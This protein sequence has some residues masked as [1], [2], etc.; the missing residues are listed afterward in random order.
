MPLHS[1]Y[2]VKP[3][4]MSWNNTFWVM[5]LATFAFVFF[6]LVP[7]HPPGV[8]FKEY[9]PLHTAME[10]FA[11]VIAGVTFAI[12]WHGRNTLGTTR[13]ALCAIGFLGVAMLDA[14]HT[15]SYPGMPDW[16]TPSSDEKAINFWFFARYL[17]AFSILSLVLGSERLTLRHGM[18]WWILAGV[19][20]IVAISYWLVFWH[21]SWLPVFIVPQKG[22]TSSKILMEWLL[23]A[24]ALMT[25]V[26]IWRKRQ[27]VTLY[28]PRFLVAALWLGGLSE[29]CFSLYVNVADVFNL[30]GHVYKALSY[31][32]LYQ[33]IVTGSV[34]LPYTLLAQ[35]QA[36]TQQLIQHIQEVFWMASADK[37]QFFFVSPAY[38]T[39]WQRSRDSLMES[40]NSWYEAIHPEDREHV[41]QTISSQ[42]IGDY[43]LDYRIVRPDGS[44]RWI[45]DKAFPICDAKGNVLRIAGVADDITEQVKAAETLYKKERLLNQTQAIAH[46]GSWE[47]DLVNN[48][49][50]WSDEVY[51][52]FGLSPQECPATYEAFLATVHPDDRHI[53]DHS[54]QQSLEKDYDYYEDE[55]RIVRGDTQ[56][57]RYVHEKCHHIRDVYGKVLRSICMV[58]DI[59]ERK[60]SE[61]TRQQMDIN[62]RNI[63]NS[64]ADAIIIAGYDGRITLVNSQAEKWFGYAR[65]ELLDQHVEILIPERF[66]EHHINLRTNY[67][68][69]PIARPMGANSELYA[70]RKDGSEFP[71]E[72]S[73]SPL[74]TE[75]GLLVTAI[76]HD[77]T[78]RK[79][80][81][82]EREK[83]QAQLM[84]SQKMEAI[85]H[86]TGGIAHD[87]N[88]MLGIIL[89]YAGMLKNRNAKQ[90]ASSTHGTYIDEILIAGNRAKELISQM[91]VFSRLSPQTERTEAPT[92]LLQPVVK[93][94]IQLLHSSIPSTINVNYLIED[95]TLKA[96]IEPVQLHQ[97]LLNLAINARDAIGKYGRIY[98][99]VGRR[100]FVDTICNSCHKDISG[101]YVVLS[102]DDTGQGI[103]DEALPR[104]FEPFFTTKK[105]G[106]GTGMGLSMV[107][108]V[109]HNLG[110][111]ILVNSRKEQGTTISILL[112]IVEL[113][114]MN[115]AEN[116]IQN[117]DVMEGALSNV[118][119]MVVDDE[120]GISFMLNELLTTCGAQVTVFNRPNDAISA[121]QQN[122]RDVDLVI[123]DE[124]MP[125][126]S[127][128]DMAKAMISQRPGLPVI[129]CT[130]YGDH[131]NADIAKRHGISGFVYKPLEIH[132]LLELIQNV[133]RE[134]RILKNIEGGGVETL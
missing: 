116:N 84:Q 28:D 105:A 74:E 48:H 55:F 73:L 42:T 123:T 3:V 13:L 126:V 75:Q 22:L 94:I 4:G 26:L 34:K 118:R 5:G 102:V 47:Y 31:G 9:T 107:H 35:S 71:V 14:L 96:R 21:S 117:F 68:K 39:I 8:A 114:G 29:L 60:R 72:I 63:L 11:I 64:A 129:L 20:A 57:I 44:E 15:L 16:I 108:G 24:I 86:L 76:I 7:F 18:E 25:L 58:H 40:P 127:G 43:T 119:I 122:P 91:M 131:V 78:D 56:E 45:R 36:I 103:A 95:E 46:L 12:G 10:I 6:W 87:F 88:N 1:I 104:L 111:H 41:E 2:P 67:A 61:Q 27:Q 54:Y 113:D 59:T 49:L 98:L 89:G 70:L 121:F 132:D 33:A 85:G 101:E 110:G 134:H 99:T 62:F 82:L 93:E 51:R 115:S 69:T 53:V 125:E 130:G 106:E 77:I 52:I 50:T 112:P 30:M 19:L 124:T 83:L 100:T 120:Q 80:S 81:E 37:Q 65:N 66:R 128:L 32:F 23:V 79:R 133:L 38:E 17:A 109:V 92:T 90:A 97:I